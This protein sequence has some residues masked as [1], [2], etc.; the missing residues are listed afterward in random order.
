MKFS[1]SC[2]PPRLCSNKH[3]MNEDSLDLAKHMKHSDGIGNRMDPEQLCMMNVDERHVAMAE[4]DCSIRPRLAAFNYEE[5]LPLPK[6][7]RSRRNLKQQKQESEE[8]SSA[9]DEA[10]SAEESEESEEESA[11]EEEEEGEEWVAQV[12]PGVCITLIALPNGSN[13]LKRIRFW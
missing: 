12:E 2:A 3:E 5:I 10:E 8:G 7:K 1:A 4:S 13:S 6:I 9:M 11:E